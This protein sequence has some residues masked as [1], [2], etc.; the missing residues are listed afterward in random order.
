MAITAENVFDVSAERVGL[1]LQRLQRAVLLTGIESSNPI[2]YISQIATAS[3]VP[4]RS[5]Y[6]GASLLTY[7]REEITIADQPKGKARV[8]VF[9]ERPALLPNDESGKP[10]ITGRASLQ[11]I[12]TEND[13]NSDP[14]TVSY[15]FPADDPDWPS[16]TKVQRGT[17]QVLEPRPAFVIPRIEETDEPGALAMQWIGYLNS[18][19]WNNAGP[20]RWMCIDVPFEPIDLTTNPQKW[21]LAYQF[22]RAQISHDPDAVFID[23]RTGRPPSDLV[24]GVGY[25]TIAYNPER[26]FNE[27][28][29]ADN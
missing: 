18:D 27:K 8:D 1:Y 29:P 24:A 20:R 23:P 13:A 5:I 19:T 4:R 21:L 6:I 25:K 28:F 16:E 3:A 26:S 7:R 22:E 12:T 9:Y 10:V 14:I 11:Q 15:T 2:G 17:I